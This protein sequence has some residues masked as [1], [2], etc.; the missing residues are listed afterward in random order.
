[1]LAGG[2]TTRKCNHHPLSRIARVTLPRVEDTARAPCT[3]D[4]H[5]D[6]LPRADLEHT[7]GE[8]GG[9]A[10]II[11]LGRVTAGGGRGECPGDRWGPRQNAPSANPV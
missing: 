2:V 7:E 5:Q 6:G 3:Y 8:E 1:M 9:R 10:A 11:A 4:P